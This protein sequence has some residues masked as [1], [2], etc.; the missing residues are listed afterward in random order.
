MPKFLTQLVNLISDRPTHSKVGTELAIDARLEPMSIASICPSVSC[1]LFSDIHHLTS[2]TQSSI[3][4]TVL[5]TRSSVHD[6]WSCVSPAKAWWPTEWQGKNLIEWH[7]VRNKQ[8]WPQHRAQGYT[9]LNKW[10]C[11]PDTTNNNLLSACQVGPKPRQYHTTDVC[12]N[13]A[14]NKYSGQESKNNVQ[15]MI[16]LPV[17]FKAIKP[18]MNCR[19]LSKV[20]I[21]KS[22]KDCP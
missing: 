5:W 18:G 2:L 6:H 15:H 4:Q 20:I 12:R 14:P 3:L 17:I 9:I 16:L 21:K 22:L 7:H 8:N 11:Q 1:S 13:H 19:T 10:R